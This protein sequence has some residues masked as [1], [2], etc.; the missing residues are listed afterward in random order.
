MNL[1]P[2]PVMPGTRSG[3]QLI[4]VK[5]YCMRGR[6]VEIYGRT[7]LV[8]GGRAFAAVYDLA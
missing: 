4:G 1:K 8:D 5:E 3:R 2:F 6:D 7:Y